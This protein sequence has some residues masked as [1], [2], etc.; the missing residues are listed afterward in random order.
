[1]FQ[2]LTSFYVFLFLQIRKCNDP[3]C[4]RP[5]KLS[6]DDLTWLPDPEPDETEEHYKKYAELDGTETSQDYMPSSKN[7]KGAVSEEEQVC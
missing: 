2:T 1:M 6:D 3:E 7:F 4:C 5:K